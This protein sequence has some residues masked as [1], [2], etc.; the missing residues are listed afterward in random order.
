MLKKLKITNLAIIDY[1]EIDFS[2][3]FNVVTGESGAGKTIIYK[4]INHSY[5]SL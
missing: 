4:S 1:L 3:S 5:V 2:N